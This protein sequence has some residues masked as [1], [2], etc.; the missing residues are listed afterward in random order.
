MSVYEI[1]LAKENMKFSSAH[2]T[3]LEHGVERLH[4]HN[5]RVVLTL[6]SARLRGGMLLDFGF[7][8]LE[9]RRLCAE[10]D[11]TLLLPAEC[12]DLTV[13]TRGGE[14]EVHCRNKRYVLPAEDC[15]LLPIPNVT[16][17]CL[18]EYFCRTLLERLRPRLR[19][20]GVVALVTTVEESPGQSGRCEEVLQPAEA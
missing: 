3:V 18:A 12:P 4:G 2:F 10:L 13:E 11:E 17:E 7:L 15:R 16:C 5:Y 8:K 9:A 19:D 20:A 1:T 6:K 14:L